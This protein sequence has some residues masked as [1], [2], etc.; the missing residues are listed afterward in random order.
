MP[1]QHAAQQCS[2]SDEALPSNHAGRTFDGWRQRCRRWL[3]HGSRNG[4]ET[5][6]GGH[7]PP[8]TPLVKVGGVGEYLVALP[9]DPETP[10][11]FPALDGPRIWGAEVFRYIFPSVQTNAAGRG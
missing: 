7:H 6:G 4:L 9:E 2:R 11:L 3:C 8:G 5:A 1:G 10:F